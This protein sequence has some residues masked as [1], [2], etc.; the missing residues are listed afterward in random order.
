VTTNIT[1]RELALEDL[2]TMADIDRAET[3]YSNYTCTNGQLSLQEKRIDVR[4][5]YPNAVSDHIQHITASITGGGAAFGAFDDDLLV[6]IIGLCIDPV[7]G[8][9]TIMQLEPLFVSAPYRN[10]GIGKRLISMVAERARSLGARG[11]YISSIPTRNSVDAYLRLRAVLLT[12][13]D[14]HLFEKEPE[15]I[16]LM[17]PLNEE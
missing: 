2:P 14:P 12:T 4:G 9:R 13:P 15:D 17:L 11:L 7:S 6:G 8:D 5:W 16:H 10:K 1:F 3:I